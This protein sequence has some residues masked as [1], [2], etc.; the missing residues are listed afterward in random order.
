MYSSERNNHVTIL[1]IKLPLGPSTY[2]FARVGQCQTSFF[3]IFSRVLSPFDCFLRQVGEVGS[4]LDQILDNPTDSETGD[5]IG[6]CRPVAF[7]AARFWNRPLRSFHTRGCAPG[8]VKSKIWSQPR[9]AR[10]FLHLSQFTPLDLDFCCDF[11][12]HQSTFYMSSHAL[13]VHSSRPI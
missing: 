10:T 2:S 3:N 5:S 1:I 8:Q 7:K 12:W 13:W 11:L 9:Q 4:R 6:Y